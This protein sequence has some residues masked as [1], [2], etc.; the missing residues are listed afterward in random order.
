ML[1]R[2]LKIITESQ[3]KSIEH[4]NLNKEQSDSSR[5]IIFLQK[6]PYKGLLTKTQAINLNQI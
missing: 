4:I 6:N 2:K 5:K 1:L 3:T